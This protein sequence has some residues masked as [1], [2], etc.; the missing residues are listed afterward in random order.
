ME[1]AVVSMLAF[2][3]SLV[4]VYLN[5]FFSEVTNIHDIPDTIRKFHPAKTPSSGGLGF[6]IAFF[7]VVVASVNYRLFSTTPFFQSWFPFF[8]TGAVI[9]F[10]LG[11][12]DDI[13]GLR[14]VLKF[15][16]QM[17]AGLIVSIGILKSY[18]QTTS[19][20]FPWYVEIGIVLMFTFLVL[21]SCNAVNLIDGIDGLAASQ[22][23]IILA[24]LGAV[25]SAWGISDMNFVIFP[26]IAAVVG[27]LMFNR[28][29]ATIFMGDT[30]S[31]LL[32]YSI[33]SIILFLGTHAPG[34]YH[35]FG[36]LAMLGIPYL[37]TLLA[38]IRRRARG[39][40]AF[41]PDREHIHHL[42]Q[43]YFRSPGMS[44]AIISGVTMLLIAT[45]ILL[46]HT[47]DISLYLTIL[48]SLMALLAVLSISY[49]KKVS[50]LEN[51]DISGHPD[52]VASKP[53]GIHEKRDSGRITPIEIDL[54]QVSKN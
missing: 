42:M 38:I 19:A 35:F 11:I 43:G 34:W 6:G 21:A 9:V 32:G 24:G 26:L 47:S 4:L 45:A 39:Q 33:I 10:V 7:G 51:S 25:A 50:V 23:T 1:V 22:S 2:L 5:H 8:M 31:L 27:F 16:V 15:G 29:P 12:I 20:S 48:S 41:E 28:P 49:Y 44:V 52:P 36:L 14:S 40:S 3:G 54:E 18:N 17:A 46:A 13:K 30:G 37:D 53:E